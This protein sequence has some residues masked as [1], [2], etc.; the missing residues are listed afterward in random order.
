MN[1][2][3]I[4]IPQYAEIRVNTRANIKPTCLICGR[5]FK[6]EVEIKN[7]IAGFHE[8][9]N[10]ETSCSDCTLKAKTPEELL[11]HL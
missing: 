1:V 2:G 10:E 8:D 11:K 4:D 6:T 3:G 5:I 9:D 7:H